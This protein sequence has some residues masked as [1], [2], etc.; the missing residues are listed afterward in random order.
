M[1]GS[2]LKLYRNDLKADLIL[3]GSIPVK[4]N[5]HDQSQT[6]ARSSSN[7][8]SCLALINKSTQY[9]IYNDLVR[10]WSMCGL[11]GRI[12]KKQKESQDSATIPIQ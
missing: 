10:T 12:P 2:R 8:L 7:S 11:D 5:D 3:D 9:S 6:V 1:V 4:P